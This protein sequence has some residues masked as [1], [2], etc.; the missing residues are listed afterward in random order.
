[1]DIRAIK[2]L[3]GVTTTQTVVR[4]PVVAGRAVEPVPPVAKIQPERPAVQDQRDAQAAV[5]EHL[6]DY[7]RSSDRDLEF[8]VDSGT[9]ATVITVRN[10]ETGD[11]VRQIPNET[12]LRLMR[13]LNAESGTLVDLTA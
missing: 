7:L 3:S 11:I 5:S 10:G 8:R 6:G 12:A 4:E 1:M 2:L 9:H 13:L